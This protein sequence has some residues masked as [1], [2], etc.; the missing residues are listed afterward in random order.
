MILPNNQA[1]MTTFDPMK[2]R[3][4]FPALSQ[5]VR[6]GKPLV[7]LDNAATTQKPQVVID[8]ISD[9]YRYNNANVHRAIHE[10]SERATTDFEAARDRIQ[11]FINAKN[12][13][14]IIFTRGTTESI[15]LVAQTWGRS[16]LGPGDEIIISEMAHHSNIVPWQIL[17][18][19]TGCSLRYIPMNADAELVYEE[20]TKLLNNNTKLVSV[21]H[22]SNATGTINPIEKIIT[23]AHAV[24]AMVLIDAAQSVAHMPVDVQALDADFLAFSAHKAFGPTGFGVLYG[25]QSLLDAM[26][27]WHGGG[28][29]IRE[30]KMSGSTWADLPNKFEAGTPHIAGAIATA[31]ALDYIDSLDRVA[32][33]EYESELLAYAEIALTEINGFERI[34]TAHHRAS[35]ISFV[36]DNAHASDIGTILDMEG[37]AVRTGHHCAMPVMDHFG[38][39]ATA[40]ASLACYNTREDIDAFI[41]GLHK[42]NDLFG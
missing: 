3:A 23:D 36:M 39:S 26:P 27:P 11:R 2:I 35:I 25:K 21:G 22:I 38:V 28:D 13:E 30:V 12:R 40:R 17:R 18:D 8:A 1:S 19:Q 24:N 20:F 33:A 9:Y 31:A 32:I 5:T 29:M 42:I 34:G 16:N 4:D 7:Y 10:L 41:R 37:V 14:E 15:N 6:D